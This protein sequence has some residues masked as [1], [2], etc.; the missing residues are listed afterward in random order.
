VT[1][2]APAFLLAFTIKA[3]S[4]NP[5]A[6]FS[7]GP[8]STGGTA[9]APGTGGAGGS[10]GAGASGGAGGVVIGVD[11]GS[12]SGGT[13]GCGSKDATVLFVIDRSASMKCNLPPTTSSP[14]CERTPEKIDPSQPSKWEI[15]TGVLAKSFEAL[16]PTSA[17]LKVRAGLSFFSVDDLCGARSLPSIPMNDVDP[18][19]VDL[20]R[21]SLSITPAGGTPIVGA[22]ILAYKH[23]YQ[24][25][26]RGEGHVILLTDGADSCQPAY[27]ATV[28]PGDHIAGLID[29]E[30][31]KAL[32]AGIKTWV[33]GAPG[34]EPA[35]HMLSSLAL[36][37][38]TART[39]C[40][41]GS[42]ADPTSGDCHYDMT[43][44]D[45]ELALEDALKQIV[46][47]VTCQPPS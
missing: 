20:L 27:E 45:F 28:G 13:S 42:D 34:S 33:I 19:Q 4:A 24:P 29:V 39:G 40:N 17:A 21:Q 9:G 32:R 44:D 25:T 31:P 15:V 46:S 26:F 10:T 1:L 30:A 6:S 47:V 35:R 16:V 12:S 2:R 8:V 38:G 41:P 7:D 18:V 5:N 37:G 43:T 3:C 36:A 11:G 22:T 23:I 14:D